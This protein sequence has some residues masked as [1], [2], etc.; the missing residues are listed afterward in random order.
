MV[1]RRSFPGRDHRYDLIVVGAGLAGCE[2][3]Y[4]AA[5]AGFDTLLVTTGLDTV[6]TLLGDGAPLAPPPGTLM[7]E[8]TADL[9]G[10]DGVVPSWGLHRAAKYALEHRPGIHLLQSSVSSLL[11][12]GGRVRGVAT[13]E[14]VDRHG[15]RVALCVGSFLEA[16]L[17]IGRSVEIA[18]RLSEMA[19]DD[20]YRDL[21]EHGFGFEP[22]TLEAQGEG[23]RLPYRVECRVFAAEERAP[24][25]GALPRLEG[26]YAAG[27]CLDGYL[28]FE[29]AAARGRALADELIAGSSR[30]Q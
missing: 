9:L 27:V 19:Y 6:Y 29:L 18:G 22:L 8:L 30:R 26:L 12:D 15:A 14:G 21:L 2:A 23:G 28:P 25:G 20:L 24:S 13:W 7:A 4:A 16:R 5:G 1:A 17:H 3:A 10:A 11:V